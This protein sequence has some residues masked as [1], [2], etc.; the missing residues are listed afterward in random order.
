MKEGIDRLL[1]QQWLHYKILKEIENEDREN[2]I[3]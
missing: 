3:I 1:N 2:K